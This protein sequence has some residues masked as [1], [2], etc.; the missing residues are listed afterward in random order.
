MQVLPTI[1]KISVDA[2]YLG[3]YC[4]TFLVF[5][6]GL[7]RYSLFKKVNNA[8][9]WINLHPMNGAIS[10]PSTHPLDSHLSSGKRYPAYEQ[11]PGARS[12]ENEAN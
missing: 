1:E 2:K 11:L 9:H 3:M 10:F 5:L 6:V 7:L 4:P 8:I 12:S